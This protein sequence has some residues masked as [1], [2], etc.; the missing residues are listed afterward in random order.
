MSYAEAM[1]AAGANVLEFENFGS[2]QGEWWALVTY[3]GLTGFVNG[4]FGSCSGCDAF[5]REFGYGEDGWCDAH[6]YA[7]HPGCLGCQKKKSAY[8]EKLANFGR[9]YLD[10][11]VTAEDAITA[12]S[13]YIEWDMEAKDMV[14][15]IKKVAGQHA[16]K[17]A[18]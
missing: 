18:A 2:Y 14:E 10:A 5:E 8:Q 11:I 4:S 6:A 13:K 1:E 16:L 15:W 12:A 3:N 9:G 17:V 7:P